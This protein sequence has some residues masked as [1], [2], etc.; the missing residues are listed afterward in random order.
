MRMNSLRY[1]FLLSISLFFPC[2]FAS[3]VA[4]FDTEFSKQLVNETNSTLLK[5]V[6]DDSCKDEISVELDKLYCLVAY[7]GISERSLHGDQVLYNFLNEE[8][9]LKIEK[10][11]LVDVW[12][13]EIGDFD[14]TLIA[15]KL[16]TGENVDLSI[17]TTFSSTFGLWSAGTRA[18]VEFFRNVLRET[19]LVFWATR[20]DDVNLY[21][22]QKSENKQYPDLV[23][24]LTN[25]NVENLILLGALDEGNLVTSKPYGSEIIKSHFIGYDGWNLFLS[26]I[27][28]F[29]TSF[30]T[31][32]LAASTLAKAVE[33]ELNPLDIIRR[34]RKQNKTEQNVL[35]VDRSMLAAFPCQKQ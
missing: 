16:M 5:L 2:V 7:E 19:N 21:D 3:T 14:P 35:V 4:I 9:N 1:L 11:F 10:I 26:E 30:S 15:L 13:D 27:Y 22:L 24:F 12:M 20:N 34:I 28:N 33:C 17:V 6:T 23:P 25:E 18:E 29:G 31:P 32:K 8:K